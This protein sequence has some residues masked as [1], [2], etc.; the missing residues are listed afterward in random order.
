MMILGK[1]PSDGQGEA[2][3]LHEEN[4]AQVPGQVHGGHLALQGANCREKR[5][6]RLP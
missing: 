2:G 4:L 1:Q 6:D 5:K 3:I